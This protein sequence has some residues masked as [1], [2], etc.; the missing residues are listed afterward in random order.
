MTYRSALLLLLGVFVLHFSRILF[1]GDVIFPHDNGLEVGVSEKDSS[2]RISNRK[3]SDE[4]SA[5]I[6]E[7]ANNLRKDRKNWLATW[8]PHV[9][10]GRASSPGELSRAFVFT[11]L[12]SLFTSNPFVLYTALVLLT[13]ALTAVFFL[14]FLRSLGLHPAACACG[15][16]GLAF[17]TPV[18]YW[19]CFVMFV[20]AICW[21]VCL[22]W[23][24]TEFTRKPS[25]PIALGMVFATYCL[26]ITSYPQVTIL[27]AYL[28]GAYALI[29]LVQHPSTHREKSRTL[30][31]MLGCAAAG[32]VMT[33]PIFLDLLFTAK[34]SARLREVSDNFFIAVL[35][36]CRNLREL[37]DFLVTLFDWSWLGNAIAPNYPARFN[38]LSFTPFYGSLIWLSFILKNRRV[39][40]FW[41]IFLIASLAATIFP[42]AYLFAV[43]HL[44]FG[45]SRIQLA[46]GG[47][48]PG[49]V[50]SALSIDAILRGKLRLTVRS[51]IW[52]LIPLV[53]ESMVALL[54]WNRLTINAGAIVITC[55][56]IIALLCSLR[57]R[58]IPGFIA[59]AVAST[60]LYGRVLILSRPLESIHTS[61]KLVEAIKTHTPDGERF[62]I[63]DSTT[64]VLPPNQEALLG[65]NSVNSYDSLSSRRYQELVKRWSTI[66]TGTYGRYF[67]SLDA[68]QALAD[69]T[70][71]FSN[72]HLVLSTRP[73]T[74]DGLTLVAQ[75]KRIQTLR[76]ERR[77]N[78]LV[79]NCAF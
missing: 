64:A 32:L 19:L 56:L 58:S 29:T 11:N 30:L 31:A 44:G 13:V 70:F 47:I 74:T 15:A 77:T 2:G 42:G 59:I 62:A 60:L 46:G 28:I 41:Q 21:P 72:V 20:S 39:T 3:F 66:G 73:L 57:W 68:K 34:N 33:L 67:R 50:L 4:S 40:L 71:P 7:L 48:I 22:L 1:C 9:Q 14:L 43:H 54:I 63:A 55:V 53:A 10:L 61:S 49:F 26:L 65:L 24:L 76:N 51:A 18:S 36:P 6:P 69:P 75:T 25:W 12:F 45:L 52:L 37:S 23:L 16:L 78:W 8:N 27:S 35:P 17:T 5:F 79:A 38:G